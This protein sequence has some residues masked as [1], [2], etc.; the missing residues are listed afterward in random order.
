VGSS[1]RL[2]RDHTERPA[3]PAAWHARA[4]AP[5][6]G[7]LGRG[8]WLRYGLL[9]YGFAIPVIAVAVAAKRRAWRLGPG[10]VPFATFF[11]AVLAATL[12]DRLGPQSFR[13]PRRTVVLVVPPEPEVPVAR[14]A[15]TAPVNLALRRPLPGPRRCRRSHQA[16]PQPQPRAEEHLL[17]RRD[18]R[19]RMPRR[20]GATSRNVLRICR[21]RL[22]RAPAA[23]RS[24]GRQS[25]SPIRLLTI[26]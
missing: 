18:A 8:S 16:L 10:L 6:R 17:R 20:S 14:S 5:S 9:A 22:R 13:L 7:D 2:R 19:S 23:F 21:C 3:P 24:P 15:A 25:P 11:P 1:W 12:P 4:R 26:Y